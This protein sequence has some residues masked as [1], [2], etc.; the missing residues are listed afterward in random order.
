MTNDNK[1]S[2]T[3]L[4]V[5][6][7]YALHKL[8][9]PQL[10]KAGVL[11]LYHHRHG[12]PYRWAGH[13]GVHRKLIDFFTARE[14]HIT[15]VIR[16]SSDNFGDFEDSPRNKLVLTM[17]AF[18]KAYVDETE[19]PAVTEYVSSKGERFDKP[20]PIRLSELQELL[21]QTKRFLELNQITKDAGK[22]RKRKK[23]KDAS[24]RKLAG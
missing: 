21:E 2:N 10:T 20:K 9:A 8:S 13:L 22:A 18:E 6:R 24:L 14:G 15:K 5:S 16:Y 11:L 7:Y 1:I 12:D 19:P 4:S 23:R 17:E 3:F